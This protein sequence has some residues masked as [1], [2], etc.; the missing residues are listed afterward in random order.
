MVLQGPVCFSLK[1]YSYVVVPLRDAYVAVGD[2]QGDVSV[3]MLNSEMS[4]C[5]RQLHWGA[6]TSFDYCPADDLLYAAGE[7]DVVTLSYAAD[8]TLRGKLIGH[9]GTVNVVLVTGVENEVVTASAD[10]TMCVWN[11]LTTSC[12]QVLTAHTDSVTCLTLSLEG[13]VM[14]SGAADGTVITWNVHP[15]VPLR[16]VVCSGG[17]DYL[18]FTSNPDRLLGSVTDVGIVIIPTCASQHLETV[19]IPHSG[20]IYQFV[21]TSSQSRKSCA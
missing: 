1:I 8:L 6:I 17:L 20:W 3:F 2:E 18:A 7:D 5:N 15:Y 4:M 11:S 10:H 13:D 21:F 14:V 12:T 9:H 16:S 19:L